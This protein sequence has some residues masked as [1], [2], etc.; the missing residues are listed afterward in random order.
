[1]KQNI[2][3]LLKKIGLQDKEVTVYLYG[4]AHPP[5]SVSVLGAG[6]QL[7]RTNTYDI[8]KS[9]SKKGLCHGVSGEYGRK[10]VMTDPDSVLK[11]IERQK[12]ELGL[13][14]DEVR[15]NLS[16]FKSYAYLGPVMHPRITYFEGVEGVRKLF[17]TSLQSNSKKLGTILS[18]QSIIDVL[19][20][21]FILNY[22]AERVSRGVYART[23][24]P[25]RIHDTHPLM[26]QH[27]QALRDVRYLPKS[28][29]TDAGVIIFDN[30]VAFITT[31]EQP[32]GTL[33]ESV[34]FAK[35]M[36][37]YFD[38]LWAMSLKK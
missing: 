6:C 20:R 24:R 30:K 17:E 22:T 23:L 4:L 2:R 27:K 12:N 37:S 3:A 25:N 21:E 16:D 19:G 10:I 9:L 38:T 18:L 15:Q 8:V 31:H 7:S 32:F 34:D 28:V 33:I 29:K 11:L 1:M 36:Q 14:E 35:T 5:L 26:S 13:L